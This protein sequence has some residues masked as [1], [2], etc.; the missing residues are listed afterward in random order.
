[1]DDLTLDKVTMSFAEEMRRK[2]LEAQS[3]AAEKARAE[4]E[5][6]RAKEEA[7][8]A[9]A[10]AL[11][12]LKRN[13]CIPDLKKQIQEAASS[14]RREEAI[15]SFALAH[16]DLGGRL[17]QN[18]ESNSFWEIYS[19][20]FDEYDRM[21][22]AFIKSEP[23][24]SLTWGVESHCISWSYDDGGEYKKYVVLKVVW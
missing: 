13:N 4:A 1:M 15:K 19:S 8:E 3:N 24:L 16:S 14:G 23:G 12:Q 9:K 20:R 5:K 21:R 6:A 10:L 18:L 17:I 2:S 7:K 11:E 22:I